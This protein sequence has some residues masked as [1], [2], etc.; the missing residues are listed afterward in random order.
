MDEFLGLLAVLIPLIIMLFE[1]KTAKAKGKKEEK[2]RVETVDT[3]HEASAT[4]PDTS[5]GEE[6][7][8]GPAPVP[9]GNIMREV[10]VGETLAIAQIADDILSGEEGKEEGKVDGLQ[11]GFPLR[12]AVVHQVILERKYF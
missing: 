7:L 1:K 12:D 4:K 9:I 6:N 2:G 5:T 8:S 10:P 3:G 11:G